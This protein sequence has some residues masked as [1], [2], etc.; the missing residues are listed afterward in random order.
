[1]LYHTN[2][3]TSFVDTNRREGTSR[4]A[5]DFASSSG[6]KPGGDES[7]SPGET[8]DKEADPDKDPH[9][10]PPDPADPSPPDD[11]GGDKLKHRFQSPTSSESLRQFR[12]RI[13]ND[14]Q[15]A[16]STGRL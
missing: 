6:E 8:I 14:A 10:D 3:R 5:N 12:T 7:L 4:R 16:Y 11:T 2:Q 13:N 9:G 1:M 15:W